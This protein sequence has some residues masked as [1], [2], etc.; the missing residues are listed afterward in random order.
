MMSIAKT[1]LLEINHMKTTFKNTNSRID[2]M[3]RR[4]IH[5]EEAFINT[6]KEAKLNIQGLEYL[7]NIIGIMIPQIERVLS[8][9]EY[10]IHELE[11]LLDAL[12][13]MSNG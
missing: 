9:Y 2:F 11:V 12:D 8:H 13:N 1:S 10:I 3:A 6:R 4:L 5:M 7:T